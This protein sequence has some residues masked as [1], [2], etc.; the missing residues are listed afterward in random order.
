MIKNVGG[1]WVILGHSERRHIFGEKDEVE[2]NKLPGGLL[3]PVLFIMPDV[4]WF[5]FQLIG[6]K[7]SHA[8]SAGIGVIACVGELLSEREAGTTSDVVYRQVKEI[9]GI[10]QIQRMHL[11]QTEMKTIHST[12]FYNF[13]SKC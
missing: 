11:S 9:A 12:I 5:Y 4:W 1:Q 7:V 2:V 10:I 3:Y 8:L 13:F 6:E